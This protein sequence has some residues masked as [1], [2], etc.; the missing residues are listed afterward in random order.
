MNKLQALREQAGL[1]WHELAQR[2]DVNQNIIQQVESGAGRASLVQLAKLADALDAALFDQNIRVTVD[3]L[4]PL[5]DRLA[6]PEDNQTT[7]PDGRATHDKES[8]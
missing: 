8:G 3:D 4:Q 2:S 1:S 5:A 6:D 7:L